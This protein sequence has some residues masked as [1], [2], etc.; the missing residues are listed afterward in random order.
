MLNKML[1]LFFS[2]DN[3]LLLLPYKLFS[4]NYRGNYVDFYVFFSLLQV[5]STLFQWNGNLVCQIVN[6]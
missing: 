3:L 1:I 5:T 6:F 2:I 4:G